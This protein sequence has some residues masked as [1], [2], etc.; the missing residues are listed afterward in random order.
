MQK[1]LGVCGFEDIAMTIACPVVSKSYERNECV[2][3]GG[4]VHLSKESSEN[5]FNQISYGQVVKI[6]DKLVTKQEE[7]HV[8]SL[9]QEHGIINLSSA[10]LKSLNLGDLIYILPIHSCL[11]ASLHS[12]YLNNKGHKVPK[13]P[14]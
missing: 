2:I 7:I 13:F 5:I 12:Y 9:S 4:G 14:S 8:C 10:T 1:N 3:Y 6:N 11:T